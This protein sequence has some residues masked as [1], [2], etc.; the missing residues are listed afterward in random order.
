ME[1][2]ILYVIILKWDSKFNARLGR[3]FKRAGRCRFSLPLSSSFR[4]TRRTHSQV[5]LLPTGFAAPTLSCRAFNL[6]PLLLF[7]FS[8]PL[9]TS[10][11]RFRCLRSSIS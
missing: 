11:H 5:R 7:P 3:W 9:L 10:L 4:S 6:I 1:R 8:F 2:L